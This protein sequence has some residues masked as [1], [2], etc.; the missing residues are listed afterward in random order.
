MVVKRSIFFSPAGEESRLHLYLPE[1]CGRDGERLPVLYM[2]DGHNLFFDHDATFG[3]S[4]GLKEFLDRWEKRLIVVGI[5]CSAEDVTRVHEYCPFDI[6]SAIYGEIRG[7]GE[8]D[9][10]AYKDQLYVDLAQRAAAHGWL[11]VA[12]T[13]ASPVLDSSFVEKGRIGGAY[14]EGLASVR[15][16]ELGYWNFFAPIFDY[17]NLRAYADS[18][19]SYVDDG[20]LRFPTELYYPIRL[21][22]AGKNSLPALREN[23]VNHIELRM[24]DLN[25]FAPH[26]VDERDV[27]FAELLLCYLASTPREDFPKRAADPAVGSQATSLPVIKNLDAV[28]AGEVPLDELGVK[29]LSDTVKKKSEPIPTGMTFGFSTSAFRAD[30]DAKRRNHS[31]VSGTPARHSGQIRRGALPRDNPASG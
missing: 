9:F 27:A 12:L 2:F 10:R 21:K 8:A 7:R 16:S 25:P 11:L 15:C 30:S 5:E 22:P 1:D 24:F 26:G 20:L 4:L 19:Q 13:A 29:A 28:R 14:F 23:G 18:I 3:K 6:K 17:D 31:C